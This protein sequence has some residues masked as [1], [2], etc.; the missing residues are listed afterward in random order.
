M[1]EKLEEA[2]HHV[3][4]VMSRLPHIAPIEWMELGLVKQAIMEYI[5]EGYKIKET[6]PLGD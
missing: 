4:A 3:D 6:N 2:M 5:E 1:Y